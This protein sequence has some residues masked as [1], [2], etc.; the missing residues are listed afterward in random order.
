MRCYQGRK[1][2]RCLGIGKDLPS[3]GENGQ[4]SIEGTFKDGEKNGLW[5]K[6]YGDGQK[7]LEETFKD[8]ELVS[9]K[10]WNSK[11]EEV[12]TIQEALK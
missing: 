12:D 10:Y 3:Y 7:W 5:T 6:W 11:G 2:G 8:G 1:D 4:K 9:M